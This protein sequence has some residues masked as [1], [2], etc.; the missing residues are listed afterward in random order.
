[1]T[2]HRFRIRAVQPIEVP[3]YA[4]SMLR[5]GFGHALRRVICV[6]K[7]ADCRDCLLGERCAYVVLFEAGRSLAHKDGPLHP[8]VPQPYIIEPPLGRERRVSPGETLDFVLVLVGSASKYLP[9]FVYAFNALGERGLS[10]TRGRFVLESVATRSADAWT[11]IYTAE[12]K[13][14]TAKDPGVNGPDLTQRHKQLSSREQITMNF[15]TPTRIKFDGRFVKT[16]E[17]H[18]V[19][20]ALLRRLSGLS[21]YHCGRPLELD[22]RSLV[23]Q[24]HSIRRVA[25]DVVWIDRDR[26][27]FRQKQR[28]KLGGFTGPIKYRGDFSSFAPFLAWGEILHVG[29]AA[30]FGLGKYE[31]IAA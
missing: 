19:L 13:T 26:Y 29:K 14:L 25:A 31:L 18:H 2:R 10:R 28:M 17:F 1:M 6:L 21:Q 4:G 30:S 12:M 23:E 20:R 3:P 5:G 24:A 11:D 7:H 16:P 15:L 27:S 9:Y 8:V 22:F